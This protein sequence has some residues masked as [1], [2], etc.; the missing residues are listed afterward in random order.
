MAYF[1]V[2]IL[3]LFS[4]DDREGEIKLETL[5]YGK[6]PRNIMDYSYVSPTC[7]LFIHGGAWISGDKRDWYSVYLVVNAHGYSYA[8]MN[9][10]FITDTN[11]IGIQ[12]D[13]TNAINTLYNLGIKEIVLVGCS[14]GSNIALLYATKYRVKQVIT[15]G[16]VATTEKYL[17]PILLPHV[18]YYGHVSV[19]DSTIY[20][21]VLAVHF[22]L[23]TITFIQQ[24]IA[25]KK[26][27]A[28]LIRLPSTGHVLTEFQLYELFNYLLK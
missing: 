1:I 20:S 13:I 19:L 17:H 23:D 18:H 7:Y 5:R 11:Y 4:C 26:K 25:L 28:K 24:S 14:A 15:I 16:T 3:T 8:S 10:R 22:E 12:E 9:Y 6:H 2:V 21:D 27:G